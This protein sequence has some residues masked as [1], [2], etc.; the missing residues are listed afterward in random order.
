MYNLLRGSAESFLY[1]S[2]ISLRSLVTVVKSTRA[3]PTHLGLPIL[4]SKV[5]ILGFYPCRRYHTET[6]KLID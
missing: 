2:Y 3:V 1:N 5:S 4:Y 6:G